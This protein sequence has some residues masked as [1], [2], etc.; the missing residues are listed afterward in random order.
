MYFYKQLFYNRLAYILH[1]QIIWRL[2]NYVYIQGVEKIHTIDKDWKRCPI[3]C[4][5]QG[6]TI[7]PRLWVQV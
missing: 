3:P 2:H 6:S 4:P 7:Q 1:N 5:C